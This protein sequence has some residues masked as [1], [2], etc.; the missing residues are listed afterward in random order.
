MIKANEFMIFTIVSL[1]NVSS[2]FFW[3]L[4]YGEKEELVN[5]NFFCY[6]ENRLG[7]FI[8]SKKS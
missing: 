8:C 1:G 2:Y 4:K 3:M 6:Y 7:N 5:I